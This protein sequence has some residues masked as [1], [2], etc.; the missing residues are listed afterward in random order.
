MPLTNAEKQVRAR[1]KKAATV[2]RYEAA[3][4]EIANFQRP[5]VIGVDHSEWIELAFEEA[6]HRARQALTPTS[7]EMEGK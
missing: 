1:K 5:T 6:R 7:H 2:A 4:R 3:L